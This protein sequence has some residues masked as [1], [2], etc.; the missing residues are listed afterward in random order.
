MLGIMPFKRK[1]PILICLTLLLVVAFITPLYH[2][3][4]HDSAMAHHDFGCNDHDW[5]TRIAA[6]ETHENLSDGHSH[7]G[8]HLHFIKDISLASKTHDL[9][10]KLKNT[11][12]AMQGIEL[13]HR[14]EFNPASCKTRII[15]P[16]PD[17]F[18]SLSGLSPPIA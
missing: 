9:T 2:Y 13:A 3:H 17:Y 5:D 12:V 6:E 7:F 18:K 16:K 1:S 11:P 4:Y 10:N 8:P 14:E 15:I